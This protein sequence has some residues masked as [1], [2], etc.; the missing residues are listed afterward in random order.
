MVGSDH[1]PIFV[2]EN[3][4]RKRVQ[5]DVTKKKGRPLHS[6]MTPSRVPAYVVECVDYTACIRV[7]P[8]SNQGSSPSKKK[9]KR[10]H[11]RDKITKRK[12]HFVRYL[13]VACPQS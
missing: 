13:P 7:V 11:Y 5:C 4:E 3:K 1:T 8:V 6:R 2:R 12:E 9:T 10:K